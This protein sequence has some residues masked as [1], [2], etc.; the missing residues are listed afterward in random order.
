MLFLLNDYI[1]D[2]DA[3]EARLA[4]RWKTLGC[5]DPRVL[6]ARDAL[7]FAKAVI[8]SHRAEDTRMEHELVGDL[9][10]LIIAKTGANAALF[11]TTGE[12]RL[13]LLPSSI[14]SRLQDKMN[15]G[16]SVVVEDIWPKA[17]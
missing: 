15:E 16:E 10:S 13:T 4:R 11:L 9:A 5:G 17:A 7:E 12:P 1:I 8:D 6:M 14:L 3:P 2:V